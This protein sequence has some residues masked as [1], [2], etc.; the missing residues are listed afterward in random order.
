MEG[1]D[2]NS[3]WYSDELPNFFT[4]SI[5][6]PLKTNVTAYVEE[7][8]L[9]VQRLVML[10]GRP[11]VGKR[12]ALMSL[13]RKNDISMATMDGQNLYEGDSKIELGSDTQGVQVLIIEHAN[14]LI[15][16][17]YATVQTREFALSLKKL[18]SAMRIFIFCLMDVEPKQLEM[19]DRDILAVQYNRNFDATVFFNCPDRD[20]RCRLFKKMF[21]RLFAVLTGLVDEVTSVDYSFLA[22]SSAYA[23]PYQIQKFV[24]RVALLAV[25]NNN[26]TVNREFIKRCLYLRSALTYAITANDN[27]QLEHIFSCAAG[28]SIPTNDADIEHAETQERNKRQISHFIVEPEEEEEE[29]N[30]PPVKKSK[31]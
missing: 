23:T 27:A 5:L 31:L 14:D 21:K 19:A 15:A 11:G 26:T 25:Q 1:E 12:T 22:D 17:A 29:E 6:G 20:T 3:L 9:P 16:G 8:V 18:A 30:E 10:F 28:I 2:E 24:Q 13:C 4:Q 7:D